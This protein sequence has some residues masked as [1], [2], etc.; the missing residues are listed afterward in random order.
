MISLAFALLLSAAPTHYPPQRG[1]DVVVTLVDVRWDAKAK[2]SH[3]SFLVEP[4]AGSM[5]FEFGD[6][7]LETEGVLVAYDKELELAVRSSRRTA[8]VV[9]LLINAVKPSPGDIATLTVG[10]WKP[11]VKPEGA[12]GAKPQFHEFRVTL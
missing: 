3:L 2:Q 7:G 10:A 5:G 4:A 1:P 9:V 8:R 12:S 6:G 11:G